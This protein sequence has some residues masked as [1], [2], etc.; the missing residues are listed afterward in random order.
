MLCNVYQLSEEP[1]AGKR[2]ADLEQWVKDGGNLAFMLGDHVDEFFFNK[3]LYKDGAGLSPVRLEGL[4]GDEE[5][6]NWVGFRVEAQN[7][8]MLQPF[9][10]QN[11]P[12]LDDVK[13][14]RWWGAEAKKSKDVA[15]LMRMTDDA[16]S[17]ALVEQGYGKGRVAV[18]TI[19]ADADWT[20]WPDKP[21]YLVLVQELTRYLAGDI[22]G[23]GAVRVGDA[24]RHTLDRSQYE[25]E[26]VIIAPGERKINVQAFPIV[27]KQP[28]GPD[29]SN[30]AAPD[31]DNRASAAPAAGEQ[32]VSALAPQDE[33]QAPAGGNGEDPASPPPENTARGPSTNWRIE[34][35]GADRRGFYDLR[36]TTTGGEPAEPILF[37]ANVDPSEGDLTRVDVDA[38]R[39][40]FRGLPVTILENHQAASQ[41]VHGSRIEIWMFLLFGLLGVLFTEQFLGWWF[42]RKR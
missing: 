39:K 14:F 21:S 6:R 28:A 34:F 25:Q 2:I 27:E 11:N 12:L 38:L 13:V 17:P 18:F 22:T 24:M 4:L 10:G 36:L 16:R 41:S 40:E 37:A 29:R 30:E 5:E 23:E 3:Y 7:H 1:A 35:E 19:P 26:A 42:G 9:A 33:E 20:D 8:E 31:E 15:V 32:F